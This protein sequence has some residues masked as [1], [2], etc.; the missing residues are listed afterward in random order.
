MEL[1]SL[2]ALIAVTPIRAPGPLRPASVPG[3]ESC[4][5]V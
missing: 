3:A 4:G 1:S 2:M 5:C